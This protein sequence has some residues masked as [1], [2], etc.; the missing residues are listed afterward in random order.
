MGSLALVGLGLAAAGGG[1][2]GGG[3]GSA[4]GTYR[5]T[6]S[7]SYLTEYNYHSMLSSINPLSLNDYGYTGLG[8][9]VAVVDS[10][11]DSNHSEFNGRTIYGYDYPEALLVMVLMKTAMAHMLLQ[12]LPATEMRQ[13]CEVSLM[14]QHCMTTNG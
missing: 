6:V 2:G 7:G 3:G 5:N 9:K 4:D 10:G 8:V 13:A 14:T 1:G 12:S 11:I